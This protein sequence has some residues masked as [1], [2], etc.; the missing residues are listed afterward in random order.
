MVRRSTL[1]GCC[2]NSCAIVDKLIWEVGLPLLVVM[3]RIWSQLP[4]QLSVQSFRPIVRSENNPS[5]FR[6]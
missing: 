1:V 5:P 6:S 2:K 4:T 3:M